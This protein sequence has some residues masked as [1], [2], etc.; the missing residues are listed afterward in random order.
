MPRGQEAARGAKK[1]GLLVA[2]RGVRHGVSAAAAL[3]ALQLDE[4][5]ELALPENW[6]FKNPD[7]ILKNEDNPILVSNKNKDA[8]FSVLILL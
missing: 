5:A 8:V 6:R 3:K 7:H 1:R 4:L 2:D